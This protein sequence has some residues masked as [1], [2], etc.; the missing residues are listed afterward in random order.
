MQKQKCP[1]TV[2]QT[3]NIFM[4]ILVSFQTNLRRARYSST[5]TLLLNTLYPCTVVRG[6][7]RHNSKYN[8]K[9]TTPNYDGM[10]EN[11]HPL[12]LR[13]RL[14]S[15]HTCGVSRVKI[16]VHEMPHPVDDGF[17]QHSIIVDHT[18]RIGMFFR[19]AS[20]V[21]TQSATWFPVHRRVLY[22]RTEHGPGLH[23]CDF[24]QTPRTLCV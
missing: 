17:T 16:T 19:A 4:N 11:Q 8:S 15:T 5:P 22:V 2:L 21:G 12:Q 1:D 13:T 18:L 7:Q 6:Q 10:I 24:K 3:R 9:F 20:I 23:S 14:H